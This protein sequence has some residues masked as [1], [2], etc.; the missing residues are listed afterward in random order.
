MQQSPHL[1]AAQ[2]T[3]ALP[4]APPLPSVNTTTKG[5]AKEHMPAL[6]GLRGLAALSV[7]IAH[8]PTKTWAW[9][10]VNFGET[11]VFLFFVLSGFLMAH[12]HLQQPFDA[13]RLRR[14]GVA[15]VARIVPLYYTVVL[16]A[17]AVSVLTQADFHYRMDTVALVRLLAFVGSTDVFWS[18]GPEFQFYG[19]FL[20]LWGIT[21]LHGKARTLALLVL[22]AFAIACYF[23]SPYLPG[24]LFISKLHIFLGGVAIALLRHALA[25]RGQQPDARGIGALQLLA[26][27]AVVGMLFP[28]HQMLLPLFPAQDVA[29]ISAWYYTDLPRVLLAALVVLAFSYRNKVSDLL[30][31]NGLVSELG[32]SSFSIYLL[33]RPVI[34]VMTY[35]G[36]FERLNPSVAGIGCLVATVLLASLVNR[37]LETPARLWIT[38]RFTPSGAHSAIARTA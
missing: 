3:I 26:C 1:Q 25:T 24:V 23:G 34:D 6:D 13:Q 8:L 17:Y 29:Q 31:G 14:F 5:K 2:G 18:V 33:H 11:G 28:Y 37:I 20:L 9:E 32:R 15:R 27:A 12:L 7:V 36:L 30:L 10:Q 4:D 19:F 38:R 16:I 21:A 35:F 22:G